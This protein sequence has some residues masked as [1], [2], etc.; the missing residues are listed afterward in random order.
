MLKVSREKKRKTNTAQGTKGSFQSPS[1]Q[2]RQSH[3][4]E[5]NVI[6]MG[7]LD[8]SEVSNNPFICILVTCI[9]PWH[10]ASTTIVLAPLRSH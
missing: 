7:I 4:S 3:R 1:S 10:Q 6:P 8:L 5:N 2:D 9:L